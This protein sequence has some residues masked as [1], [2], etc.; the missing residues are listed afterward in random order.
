MLGQAWAVALVIEVVYHE[1]A[2]SQS[3]RCRENF[4]ALTHQRVY[5][6]V[7][8]LALTIANLAG[9][10]DIQSAHLAEALQ[11]CPKIMTG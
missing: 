9:S 11:Y 1:W 10:E 3:F 5:H 8:K 6:C 7:L 4:A 2:A